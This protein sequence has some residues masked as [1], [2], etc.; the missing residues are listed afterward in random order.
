MSALGRLIKQGRASHRAVAFFAVASLIGFPA[1]ALRVLC[2]GNACQ[3]RAKASSDTPFCSLPDEVRRLIESGS[4]EGRSPD[5]M[6]V[7]GST[8]I[9]GGDT[10]RRDASAPLWP[11]TTLPD[12]ERVPVVFAGRGVVQRASVPSGTGLDDVSE[13]IAAI[14]DL[15]RPHPDVRSGESVDGLASGEIPRL[16]LEVVWKGVGS[17]GLERHPE[18]WP[19]L[20][21]LMRDGAATMDAVVGSL[22]LDPAATL[23]TIGTGGLP[24]RHGI[25]GTLLRTDQT[26]YDLTIAE[27][28]AGGEVVRAWTK[29]A[30][31]SVIATLGDHLDE[32]RH[33]KPVVGLVGTDPIDR[34]LIGGSWY[35]DGDR[36]SVAI[37]DRSASVEEQIGA[38]RALLSREDFGRDEITDLAGVV[39][40]GRVTKLDSAL[41]RLIRTAK[42][43]S[44]GSVAISVT[45]TGESEP[46]G[47]A[48]VADAR[49]VRGRIERAIR[50]SEPA[51]EAVVPGGLYLDQQALDRLKLSDDV[52]LREL[53]RIRSRSGDQLI[54]DA[55]PA[56]AITFGRY[57]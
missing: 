41:S 25:T 18:E 22:P 8:L 14:I 29:R 40:S 3:V 33:Q 48:T 12:G 30:P 51:I 46:G 42:D 6:A 4:Y 5:I 55:F 11:S 28:K 47:S 9:A 16:V 34:G 36:D 20:K 35:P 39:L 44:G 23:A 17:D 15:R 19:Q 56:I 2:L 49:V 38:A 13:T 45:A 1:G 50:T 54:A 7:T 52:V 53:L 24:S 31:D 32:K 27:E 57:C 26:S 37:L 10:F 21:Q 43:V